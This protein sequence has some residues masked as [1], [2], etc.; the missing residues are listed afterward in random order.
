MS[1]APHRIAIIGLGMALDPHLSSLRELSARVEIAAAWSPGAAR[2]A[3]A[4]A[5]YGLP[6]A[7]S[8]EQILDDASIDTVLL[9]TPPMS[10]LELVQRCAAA[11]KHVLLEKPLDVSV[12]RA[13]Q[14]VEAMEHAGRKFGIVLQHRFRP[15]SLELRRMIDNGELGELISGSASI[16]WWRPPSYYEQAG[17]GMKDRD[18]GGVLLTQAIHTLDLFQSLTGPI[19][20]VVSTAVNSGRRAI[21]T[22]D[23]VAAAVTFANDAVGAIDATTLA[24]P[25]FPERIELAC[26][27]GTAVLSAE[28]LDVFFQDGRTFHLE[29]APSAS[30]GSDP[31][32]F[33]NAA[34]KAVIGDFLD[35]IESDRPPLVDGRA[36][37]RVQALIEALLLSSERQQPVA[38][39]H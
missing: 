31:M 15:A 11:G 17:R 25:G 32:A 34:H 24:Y 33:G 4:A 13:T 27:K 8:L 30:S 38:L 23:I 39:M 10:H 6:P 16:R 14:A 36:A 12:A 20:S 19:R 37:L 2:R 26:T 5:R 29:G 1:G 21:D 7:A 35:A 3:E 28:T 18:G 22:E 9:L